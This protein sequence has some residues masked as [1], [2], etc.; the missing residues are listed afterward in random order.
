MRTLAFLL[1]LI[2]IF[3][4]PWEDA[5][6]VGALGALTRV[7]GL[8][9]AAAWLGSAL[10]A[11]RFRKPHPFHVAVSLFILWNIVSIWWTLGVD[12]TVEHIKTYLQLAT[13]AWILWDL[14][15]TPNALRAALQAYILGAFVSVGSTISNYLAGQ[16]IS[17]FE[18]R[19][20]GAGL[21]AGDLALILTLGLPI[22]WYL[23]TSTGNSIKGH[24]LRLV[25][26]A[27]IPGAL[28]ATMLTASRTALFMIVPALLYIIGTANRLR[29]FFRIL[30]LVVLIA[31]LFVLQPY[32]PQSSVDRLATVGDSITALD[33]GGR[34]RLWRASTAI[35]LEHPL[36]GIGSGALNVP[37][38][39]GSVAHNTFVSV[40]A[41]LGL[42]GFTLFV[43]MLAM[44]VYQAVHQP[45][46]YS[47]LWLTILA[48]W[49]I[50]VS[51]LTWEYRKPTWLFLSLTVISA[52]LFRERASIAESPSLALQYPFPLSP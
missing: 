28:F 15:T 16:R 30:I 26:Y 6:T 37:T 51:L 45:K 41:E 32:M 50:G 5:I 12:E 27:Y 40:L 33:L 18:E 4:I 29:P 24:V 25:N 43:V 44:V 46:S 34:V 11:G 8:V 3:S 10:V 21:N 7:I 20:T 48:V 52:S 2:L 1:S 17:D 36:W 47:G 31:A 9:A 35:F 22:A 38:E 39:L 23:A 14:Y 42:V 19:Y 49:M 13:L